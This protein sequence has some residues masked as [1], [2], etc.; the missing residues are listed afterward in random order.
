MDDGDPFCRFTL[1][2]VHITH[3]HLIHTRSLLLYYIIYICSY[4]SSTHNAQCAC[5]YICMKMKQCVL[6]ACNVY[7]YQ[8]SHVLSVSVSVNYTVYIHSYYE[9]HKRVI[10]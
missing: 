1:H 8:A 6:Y 4:T 2:V 3:H 5:A 7:L 9:E 10:I